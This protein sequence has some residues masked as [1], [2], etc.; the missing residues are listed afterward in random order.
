MVFGENPM[1]DMDPM[2][3]PDEVARSLPK[4]RRKV[5]REELLVDGTFLSY[6]DATDELPP[7]D[8]VERIFLILHRGQRHL[9]VRSGDRHQPWQLPIIEM[10]ITP[11]LETDDEPDQAERSAEFDQLIRN[12]ARQ[13]WGVPIKGWSQHTRVQMTARQNQ[14]QYEPGARRYE[15]VVMGECDEPVDL[16]D[17]SEWSR[18]FFPPRDMNL[19]L[20]ERYFDR[21][22]FEQVHEIQVVE[23]AKAAAAS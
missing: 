11:R 20:R 14:D 10:E 1:G 22:E 15:M 18:R 2:M 4:P 23:A 13:T 9:V 8:L 19:L 17:D 7:P 5:W 21:E 3:S 12:F 16:P 6:K